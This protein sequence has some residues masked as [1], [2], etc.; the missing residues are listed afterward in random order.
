[1]GTVTARLAARRVVESGAVVID[2]E[3]TGLY[4]DAEV[5]E[6]VVVDLLSGAAL[7]E[8]LVKP[9]VPVG[10][11]AYRIHGIGHEALNSAP[12]FDEVW[13]TLHRAVGD[14]AVVA[15]NAAFDRRILLQT[16]QCG[17]TGWQG[18]LSDAAGASWHCAMLAA[19]RSLGLRKWPRLD[20]A[21][22]AFGVL[23]GASHRARADAMTTRAVYLKIA[24]VI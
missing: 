17:T 12:R 11:A 3:T 14:R 21:A 20:E 24:G 6:I 10:D 23:V 19:Q 18:F 16:A 5:V 2:T 13:P 9:S 22:A 1:M 15:F 7:F 4:A 8:S